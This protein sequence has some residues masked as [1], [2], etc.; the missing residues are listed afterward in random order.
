MAEETGAK[1]DKEIIDKSSADEA[2]EMT[3]M[4]EEVKS[5]PG[6]DEKKKVKE[7]KSEKENRKLKSRIEQLEKELEELKDQYLRKQADFD[8]FRKRMFREKE[9]SIKFANT[10]LITDFITVI[11]DFE[12]ALQSSE[13]SKDFNA[14]HSGIEMIEKQMISM[15]ETNWGLKRFDSAGEPFDPEKHE[16]LMMEDSDK[17]EVQT[18]LDDFMKGYLLHDRVIRHAKVKVSNPVPAENK[19]DNLIKEN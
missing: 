11:D 8:N 3:G 18:V 12:R 1:E 9:E 13:E 17:Y 16:A 7:T 10:A 19:K 6:K 5:E 14:F 4:K 15:L 2:S